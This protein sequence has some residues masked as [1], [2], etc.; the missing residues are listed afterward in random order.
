MPRAFTVRFTA[1]I[2]VILLV[3]YGDA[4]GAGILASSI[5]GKGRKARPSGLDSASAIA[6]F[7][8]SSLREL[9]LEVPP[10]SPILPIPTAGQLAWHRR[11]LSLLVHFGMQTFGLGDGADSPRLF[12]PLQMNTT[13]WVEAAV[14]GGFRTVIL[15]AKPEDGFCLWPSNYTSYSVKSASWQSGNADIVAELVDSCG[16]LGVAVGLHLCP[17]DN[18][19]LR[20]GD[21]SRYNEYFIALHR[22]L[23][24]SY[25]PFAEVRYTGSGKTYPYSYGKYWA[26]DRQL[27]PMAQIFS[28]AGPDIRWVGNSNGQGSDT[29]WSMIDRSRLTPGTPESPNEEKMEYLAQGDENGSDWCPAECDV[30]MRANWFWKAGDR[31]KNLINLVDIYFA[32]VGRNCVL[33]L[34]LPVR[35]DGLLDLE[36][37]SGIYQVHEVLKSVFSVNFCR[38]RPANASSVWGDRAAAIRM[39]QAM[40]GQ[41]K[42]NLRPSAIHRGAGDEEESGME[43]ALRPRTDEFLEHR[44]ADDS[45]VLHVQRLRLLSLENDSLFPFGAHKAVD[46]D[47]ETYWAADA[48]ETAGTLEVDLQSPTQFNVVR[49]Q[50]PIQMGQR[51]AQ[52]MVQAWVVG[53][54]DESRSANGV[55][56]GQWQT[57]SS[58][59]TIGHK[60]LDRLPDVVNATKVRLVIIRGRANPLIAEFGLHLIRHGHFR[61]SRDER[62]TTIQAMNEV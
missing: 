27:Q 14:R 15:T 33:Q 13:Q 21:V 45:A 37:V 12:T 59:T 53:R 60:K 52:Y 50:E 1:C 61:V 7:S 56:A 62:K 49:I 22:E 38:G 20:F 41:R 24:T 57:L 32:S 19:E 51:V 16:K 48:G 17:Q 31:P 23:M 29:C 55:V 10:P 36:D 5:G 28:D 25:G 40:A 34:N 9:R 42:K 44:G 4:A 26:V 8:A 47:L 30:S 54:P 6:S 3:I 58:G 39:K 18:H 35:P 11:E 2:C 43:P 46:G